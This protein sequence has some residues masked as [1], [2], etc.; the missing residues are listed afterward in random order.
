MPSERAGDEWERID[1]DADAESGDTRIRVESGE[2]GTYELRRE[3]YGLVEFESATMADDGQGFE[4]YDWHPDE[5]FVLHGDT[6]A[7]QF[8]QML[9][10]EGAFDPNVLFFRQREWSDGR[11]DGAGKGDDNAE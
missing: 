8:A 7:E 3:E 1:E 6:E 9:R 4:R 11:S 5:R 10:K 2:H